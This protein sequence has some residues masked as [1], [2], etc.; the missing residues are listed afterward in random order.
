MDDLNRV[1]KF[2]KKYNIAYEDMAKIMLEYAT[3]GEDIACSY[4]TNKYNLT[5]YAF[6]KIRDFVIICNMVDCNICI[7]IRDKAAYNKQES[8]RSSLRHF[9]K[10][11]EQRE[12]FLDEAFSRQE[13]QDIGF[14]Y[15]EGNTV[16]SIASA[17]EICGG[18]VKKLLAKGIM[19]NIIPSPV[20]GLIKN[21]L[22]KE[23]KD[24]SVIEKLEKARTSKKK[25]LLQPLKQE[26][27][28][29]RYQLSSYEDYFFEDENVPSK[30]YLNDRLEEVEEKISDL[31]A[32]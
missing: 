1:T 16:E 13:I 20:V 18:S 8:S 10:L 32:N 23:G 6:Y 27:M 2:K 3:T 31:E 11:M 28:V 12:K 22:A 19:K 30:S 15:A 26:S 7:R 5:N 14:K 29:L 4:F 21:R 9:D 17:Y 24:M 25:M